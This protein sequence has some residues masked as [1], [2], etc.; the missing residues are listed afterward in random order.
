MSSYEFRH[1]VGL[2][3]ACV[4]CLA[5]AVPAM[6]QAWVPAVGAG[7]AMLDF[8]RTNV[9]K[10]LFSGDMAPYGGD[11]SGRLDLGKIN[12]QSVQ[13]G[14]DYGVAN[15]L[16]FSASVA[17]VGATYRGAFPEDMLDDAT[18]NGSL[19]DASLGFRYMLPWKGFAITP[20]AS[21]A[22]PTHPYS[23]HGHTAVGKGNTSFNTG[24]AVGRTLS[25]FASNVWL[26][27]GYTHEF[28][29]DV[30]QWGLDANEF[31]GSAGWFPVSR[32]TVSAYYTY[33]N[34]EDG[35]DWLND[36]FTADVEA[37]HDQAA[38]A[39]YRRVGGTLG[40]QLNASTGLFIDIGGIVSGANTHNGVNYTVGTS[41]GFLGPALH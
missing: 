3:A 6:A 13:V 35:V 26:Q 8:Q 41:W 21:F 29:R 18:F 7:N 9:N 31:T 14:V 11:T 1:A 39:L 38:K 10:H 17:Y 12:A 2:A 33:H 32:L 25:P 27:G 28:V 36:D 30:E 37:H 19:Q 5:S 15:N 24:I 16:A 20:Q 22:F 4:I 34:T 40:Y 23:R